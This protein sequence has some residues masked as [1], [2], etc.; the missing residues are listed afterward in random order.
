MRRA[1][2]LIP[3]MTPNRFTC[4]I[5]A[6]TS[7]SI[8]WI[9]PVGMIP[10][11]LTRM[12]MGPRRASTSSKNFE[13]E[14]ESATSS[15]AAYAASVTSDM[16]MSPTATTTPASASVVEIALP[17][18]RAPPVTTA[19]LPTN[20]R[21]FMSGTSTAAG[22][23]DACSD[24]I[25]DVARLT[26]PQLHL[27]DSLGRCLRHRFND[28]H[29]TRNHVARHSGHQEPHE[30]LWIQ[31]ASCDRDD[32]D[33]DLVTFIVGVDRNRRGFSDIRMRIHFRLHFEGGDVL[34][35]TTDR[36]LHPV[37]EVEASLNVLPERVTRVEPP[38]AP[39]QGRLFRHAEISGSKG[40]RHRRADNEL[41]HLPDRH[42][43][44]ELVD[45]A[46][47]PARPSGGNASAAFDVL[48]RIPFDPNRRRDLCHAKR[49]IDVGDAKPPSEVVEPRMD[50]RN[51]HSP[52][53]M[54]SVVG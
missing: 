2:S 42:L 31:R 9:K 10:A 36:I 54:L 22:Q 6:V 16:S 21:A 51:G 7:E 38:V 18:P 33:L 13:T 26:L 45:E 30:V 49:G 27:L 1:A 12:S 24:A 53:G 28:L 40:P 41:T 8:S 37:N 5:R 46:N 14:P 11:L 50:R 29:E 23:F 25:P 35:A 47:L 19:T 32:E 34:P 20:E 4:T 17:I 15:L 48:D 3:L 43:A 39:S 52:Q 44:V